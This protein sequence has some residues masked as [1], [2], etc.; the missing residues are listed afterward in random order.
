M[1][2]SQAEKL[3]LMMLC[4]IYRAMGIEN[5]FNPDLVE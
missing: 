2:Y 3:Q 1:K 4:E 5:S